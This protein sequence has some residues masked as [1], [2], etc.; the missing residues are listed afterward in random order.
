MKIV[1]K[2]LFLIF[3]IAGIVVSSFS[4]IIILSTRSLNYEKIYNYEYK[5]NKN[6]DILV[7]FVLSKEFAGKIVRSKFQNKNFDSEF[8]SFEV[9]KLGNLTINHPLNLDDSFKLTSIDIQ[10]YQIFKATYEN[11]PI[12]KPVFWNTVTEKLQFNKNLTANRDVFLI[13]KNEEGY[14]IEKNVN[15][16]STGASSKLTSSLLNL[17]QKLALRGIYFFDEKTK[18]NQPIN[19]N[20]LFVEFDVKKPLKNL[21]KNSEQAKILLPKN[22]ESSKNE[23]IQEKKFSII[24]KV[25]QN[26]DAVD[27]YFNFIDPELTSSNLVLTINSE[28]GQ[29]KLTS[30]YGYFDFDKKLYH[31]SFD[32][33][34]TNKK[35]YLSNIHYYDSKNKL[36]DIKIQNNIEDFSFVKYFEP[37]KLKE[38]KQ[39]KSDFIDQIWANLELEDENKTLKQGD[40]VKIF[41]SEG[42]KNIESIGEILEEADKLFLK[43]HF[44]V[45]PNKQIEIK[46]LE[47]FKIQKKLWLEKE[48]GSEFHKNIAKTNLFSLENKIELKQIEQT[49]FDSLK[50]DLTSDQINLDRIQVNVNF[51]EKDAK[52]NKTVATNFKN[53]NSKLV[54]DNINLENNKKYLINKVNFRQNN[55]VVPIDFSN[56]FVFDT[57]ILTL[58]ELKFK[59]FSTDKLVVSAKILNNNGKKLVLV[60]KSNNEI[61]RSISNKIQGEDAEFVFEKIDSN[62]IFTFEKIETDEKWVAVNKFEI[63]I[64]PKGIEVVKDSAKFTDLTINSANFSVELKSLDNVFDENQIISAVLTTEKGEKTGKFQGRIKKTNKKWVLNFNFIGLKSETKYKIQQLFFNNKPEKAWKNYN[65]NNQQGAFYDANGQNAEKFE[66]I[67]IKNTVGLTISDESSSPFDKKRTLK[68]QFTGGNKFSAKQAKLVFREIGNSTNKE[69]ESEFFEKNGKNDNKTII[70]LEKTNTFYELVAV[71]NSDNTRIT[72]DKSQSSKIIVNEIFKDSIPV[73]SSQHPNSIDAIIPFN[74]NLGKIK[75]NDKA[76]IIYK[77]SKNETF[78]VEATVENSSQNNQISNKNKTNL[79]YLKLKFQDLTINEKYQIETIEFG[80][81]QKINYYNKENS[82]KF[83]FQS[84]LNLVNGLKLDEKNKLLNLEV[85]SNFDLSQSNLFFNL[86][87]KNQEKQDYF[88]KF[89]KAQIEKL[90]NSATNSAHKKSNFHFKFSFNFLKSEIEK[91]KTGN[92][93]IKSFNWKQNPKKEILEIKNSATTIKLTSFDDIRTEMDKKW[94]EFAK[95]NLWK[96]PQEI[97]ESEIQLALTKTNSTLFSDLKIVK[98]EKLTTY[99]EPRYEL[100]YLGNTFTGFLKKEHFNY[101]NYN[102][103]KNPR[104][105]WGFGDT[106][107]STYFGYKYRPENVFDEGNTYWYL[108][109]NWS[110]KAS[111]FKM[112]P[113]NVRQYPHGYYV[114]TFRLRFFDNGDYTPVHKNNWWHDYISVSYEDMEGKIHQLPKENIAKP[115]KIIGVGGQLSVTVNVKK[116]LKKIIIYFN[117]KMGNKYISIARIHF[118]GIANKN[119]DFN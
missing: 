60:L 26:E 22:T 61:F 23:T 56:N 100:N 103:L 31:F 107:Y 109:N 73:F 2:N 58:K 74:D 119:K 21:V 7:N 99:L 90:S 91:I 82:E 113:Q 80:N 85:Y 28:D 42:E 117:N 50:M 83:S 3:G 78:E 49:N 32:K 88:L 34:L 5:Y 62:R 41:A 93:I 89:Y 64:E 94:A 40:I 101:V 54:F 38:I 69:L 57:A 96:F 51:N 11:A 67:T 105:I 59:E 106:K 19:L 110:D 4:G 115:E 36:N 43:F 10:G 16:D 46:K 102:I 68:I 81:E 17:D 48:N 118:V 75:E 53:F 104:Q 6:G 55:K 116:R 98:D 37:I 97:S 30:K 25:A 45:L 70:N 65:L 35:Y 39:L 71:R 14:K 13:L 1:K 29:T 95:Q 111:E 24:Q 15:V 9:D 87:L 77:N 72:V 114:E 47:P 20:D 8:V 52:T 79:Q 92:Y 66:F 18:M 108:D 76:K 63:K 84:E 86:E 27:V 12:F 44:N 33:I 112:I